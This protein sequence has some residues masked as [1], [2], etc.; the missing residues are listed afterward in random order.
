MRLLLPFTLC[1]GTLVFV[2]C[3]DDKTPDEKT[4]KTTAKTEEENHVH[5]DKGPHGGGL[6]ELGEE[7]YH[8]E[9]VID[10]E[11]GKV[12]IYILDGHVEEAVPIDAK[13]VS[14]SEQ[15]KS[16][17]LQAMPAEGDPEGKSSV[18]VGNDKALADLL[19]GH[20][21]AR[22]IVKIGEESFNGGID[23]H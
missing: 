11:S 1:L 18:F 15:S 20:V 17:T 10:K 4:E 21:H 9:M 14:I 8:A 2:G 5:P 3:G 23:S 22:L 12:T 6:I 16:Y 19:S 13:E 7:Q